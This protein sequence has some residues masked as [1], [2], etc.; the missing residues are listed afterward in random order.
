MKQK[1]MLVLFM[2]ALLVC[3]LFVPAVG[4]YKH[5]NENSHEIDKLVRDLED[6]VAG[7]NAAVIEG[8]LESAWNY[9][10]KIDQIITELEALGMEVEFTAMNEN[11]GILATIFMMPS[12]V[13]V[14]VNPATEQNRTMSHSISANE[15]QIEVA[16]QLVGQ[17]ITIGE[18]ME[19][20]LPEALENMPEKAVEDMFATKMIWPGPRDPSPESDLP[21]TATKTFNLTA[22][23]PTDVQPQR[24]PIVMLCTSQ[25]SATWPVI[26]FS[27]SN[28]MLLPHPWFRMPY[29]AV[30][31]FLHY[32][33]GA[34]KDFE[35]NDDHNVYKVEASGSYHTNT[36]GFYQT[37]GIH[38][39]I[40]P[41]GA[42]PP[43]L[44]GHSSTPWL[45]VA[46]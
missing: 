43:S 16:N 31:S 3:M 20:V 24:I 40:T 35:F 30:W 15:G 14:S 7:Y 37:R 38:H 34:L 12:T 4:A 22:Q 23:P 8:G 36:A 1:R 9:V 45:Y 25:I 28:R 10:E 21:Q 29:M 33:D 2:A 19:Q 11:R 41:P 42:T 32:E 18:F 44:W 13:S 46:S 26:D 5:G 39:A 17:D 6:A 27:S